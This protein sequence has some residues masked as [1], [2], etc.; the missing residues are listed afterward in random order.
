VQPVDEEV[1]GE[2][3]QLQEEYDQVLEYRPNGQQHL[4]RDLYELLLVLRFVDSQ[5]A[6]EVKVYLYAL[7]VGLGLDECFRVDEP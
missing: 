4:Y 5:G 7:D 6:H 3:Q 2:Q 1:L